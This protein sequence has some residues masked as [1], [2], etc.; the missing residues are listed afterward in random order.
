M[1]HPPPL[2]VL[3]GDPNARA[4]EQA[5]AQ[6]PVEI[7]VVRLSNSV[8]LCETLTHDYSF[9]ALLVT[10]PILKQ[11]S[12]LLSESIKDRDVSVIALLEREDT[13][14]ELGELVTI[15]D[16]SYAKEQ[17]SPNVVH[18]ILRPAIDR[19]LRTF[20]VSGRRSA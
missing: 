16:G 5:L 15:L 2:R 4:L 19:W 18:R 7:D 10:L 17:I 13:L 11:L 9:D 1:N 12:P 6:A 14:S 20:S 3:L 8:E